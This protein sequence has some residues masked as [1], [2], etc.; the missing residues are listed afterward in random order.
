MGYAGGLALNVL[1]FRA[2]GLNF[3][4]L[5]TIADTLTSGLDIFLPALIVIFAFVGGAAVGGFLSRRVS[6][7]GAVLL[8]G[9]AT[10]TL[11]ALVIWAIILRPRPGLTDLATIATLLFLMGPAYLLVTATEPKADAAKAAQ[12]DALE[13]VQSLFVVVLICAG[14]LYGLI[15]DRSRDGFN[16]PLAAA[17][18]CDCAARGRVMWI[19]ERT[20]VVRCRPG[21][22]RVVSQAENQMLALQGAAAP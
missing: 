14:G 2:W 18:V 3:L 12:T 1:V 21:D 15:A 5:A 13:V 16:G 7:R 19:G 6:R 11:V 17:N 8:G 22:V 9:V 4:Q 10:L 20:I